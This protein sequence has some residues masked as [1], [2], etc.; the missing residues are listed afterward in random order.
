MNNL[1][2]QRNWRFIAS[3]PERWRLRQLVEAWAYRSEPAPHWQVLKAVRASA[4]PTNWALYFVYAPDGRLLSNHLFTLGRLR[5]LG[6]AVL[7]VFAAP[8]ALR[9][10]NIFH[11]LSRYA[12]A[13]IWKD[14]Q[15]FDFSA[16]RIGLHFLKNNAPPES[17]AFVMNDSVYGPFSQVISDT[18][19]NQFDIVGFTSSAAIENHVQSYAFIVRKTANLK[20]HRIMDVLNPLRCF[21]DI[22]DVVNIQESR[23][24][25]RIASTHTIGSQWH[26][27]SR[28]L[29]P[30]LHYAFDL[31]KAGFPFLKRSLLT[32]KSHLY[33]AD[34]VKDWLRQMGHPID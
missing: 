14:L 18:W 32:K 13:L 9:S 19:L 30:V 29:N 6:Y 15:G 28:N 12:D 1:P 11:I 17:S 33:P 10:G 16:Y 4:L 5:D 26:S 21:N 23:F 24:A 8:L 7:V 2:L 34:Q 3:P 27:A 20:L 22:N 31:F 25:R